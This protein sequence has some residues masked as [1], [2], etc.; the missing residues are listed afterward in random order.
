LVCLLF[1]RL[2]QFLKLSYTLT[3]NLIKILEYA[4]ILRSA[5]IRE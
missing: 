1:Q 4:N 2:R 3:F 5:A